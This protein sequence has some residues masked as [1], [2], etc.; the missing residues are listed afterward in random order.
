M[1]TQIEKQ[2]EKKPT[3]KISLESMEKIDEQVS[4]W[5]MLEE[6]WTKY[7]LNRREQLEH[8]TRIF[9]VIKEEIK[10]AYQNCPGY[11]QV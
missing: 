9:Q 10:R 3:I 11:S 4:Q 5:M 6:H 8:A 2:E 7:N 1:Q